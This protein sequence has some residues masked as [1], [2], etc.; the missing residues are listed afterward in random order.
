MKVSLVVPEE[1]A[2]FTCKLRARVALPP[3]RH[4]YASRCLEGGV[5]CRKVGHKEQT[6]ARQTAPPRLLAAFPMDLRQ[7]AWGILDRVA[8][9]HSLE[10]VYMV[11][12]FMGVAFSWVGYERTWEPVSHALLRPSVHGPNLGFFFQIQS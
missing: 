7:D 3:T 1:I 11:E 2:L 6:D 10:P 8:I 4:K 5:T 12:K 9:L